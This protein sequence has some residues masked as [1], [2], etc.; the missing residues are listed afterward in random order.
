MDYL[1]NFFCFKFYGLIKGILLC[2]PI[3]SNYSLTG[4]G[5]AMVAVSRDLTNWFV[6]NSSTSAWV[7]I[8]ALTPD[9]TGVANL[10]SKGMT[11]A[12]LNALTATAWAAFYSAT[13]GVP[14]NLAVAASLSVVNGLT[15]NVTVDSLAI[16]VN[17]LSSWKLQTAN[18]VEIRWKS[19][20]VSFKAITT[21]NYKLAYQIP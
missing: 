14:D 2:L 1:F 18:E 16:N 13:N 7:N 19:N 5:K 20:S 10:Q 15:D 17:E 12:A 11:A 9:A 8:G 4:G 21:G 6:Y 3:T